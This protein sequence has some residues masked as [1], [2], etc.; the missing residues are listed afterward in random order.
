MR[1]FNFM[2]NFKVNK[3]NKFN[4]SYVKNADKK[5]SKK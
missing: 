3:T 2:Y 5:L 1:S 4:S